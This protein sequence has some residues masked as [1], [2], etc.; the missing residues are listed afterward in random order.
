MKLKAISPFIIILI[1]TFPLVLISKETTTLLINGIHNQ[2]LDIFFLKTTW[3]GEGFL[4]FFTIL[5]ALLKKIKWVIAFLIGLLIHLIFIQLNK[6]IFFSDVIRPLAYFQSIGKENLIHTIDGLRIFKTTSFPSGHTTGATFAF[7]F[8]AFL[9]NNRKISWLLA[10][11][12]IC[13]AISRVYLIQ[14]FFI[15]VYFGFLFGFLS[16]VIAVY[17][18][19]KSKHKY[20][21]MELYLNQTFKLDSLKEVLSNNMKST[22]KY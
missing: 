7:T 20:S 16:A 5:I 21:W 8:L 12:A 10:I 17:L 4:L 19:K 22:S 6:L 14:H 18:T 1:I 9:I 13:V 2:I 15:D 11:L 3:L